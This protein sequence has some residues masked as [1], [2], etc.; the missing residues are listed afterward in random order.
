MAFG[1]TEACLVTR[2]LD[3][4]IDGPDKSMLGLGLSGEQV[5]LTVIEKNQEL[6]IEPNTG[7][8]PHL[9]RNNGE[10]SGLREVINVNW[11]INEDLREVN[12]ER[13]TTVSLSDSD[14]GRVRK[15]E[16]EVARGGMESGLFDVDK[17]RH[18]K[19][20]RKHLGTGIDSLKRWRRRPR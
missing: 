20:K 3:S 16:S 13:G 19:E 4:R 14:K 5:G 9:N 15:G 8:G 17:G 1:R 18:G 12:G 11:D 6:S 7:G 10:G 2:V